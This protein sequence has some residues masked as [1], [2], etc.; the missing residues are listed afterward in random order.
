[1]FVD[2]KALRRRGIPNWGVFGQ[3]H[4]QGGGPMI[5]IGVH[6]IEMAHFVMGSPKPVAATGNTW[7][8]IGNND[9]SVSA[10]AFDPRNHDVYYTAAINGCWRT[11][12]GG[13]SWRCTTSWDATEPKDVCVDPNA[14]AFSATRMASFIWPRICASPRTI[15]SRPLATRK[16]WR[17]A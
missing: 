16:A 2:C 17:A 6:V 10:L 14:P 12:D 7:T 5:D 15:E 13:K 1:M 9:V 11:M 8:H 3:K 4:L